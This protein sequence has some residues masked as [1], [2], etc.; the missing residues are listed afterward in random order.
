MIRKLRFKFI[1]LTMVSLFLVLAVIMGAVNIFNYRKIVT[2]AD[3]TLS[4][5]RDNNGTFP[6]PNRQESH[7]QDRPG[8]PGDGPLSPELPY[9]SRY[10]SVLLSQSGEVLQTDTGKIA[11]VDDGTAAQF[12]RYLYGS[13][14]EKGFLGSYRY[15]V[16]ERDSGIQIIFLDC[17]RSLSTFRTFLFTSCAISVLGLLTVFVLILMFSRRI[18][19]PVSESYEKQ[20]RFTTDAGHELKTPITIIS[21][22]AE[23]LEMEFG[24]NEWIK[25]IQRQT[26]RLASLTNDLIFLSRMEEERTRL[27]EIVF[28]LSDLVS[29]TA[30]S[31]QTLAKS[32]HKT[33]TAN[34]QPMLSF[35][36]NEK[37][38]R[39][40]VCVLLDNALK[41]SGRGGCILLSLSEQKKN[42]CL[43]VENTT[44]VVIPEPPDRLFDR[45]YRADASR[46]S[47][48]EGHGLG[49]SIA[50]AVTDAHKGKISVLSPESG[51][52][53]VQVLLPAHFR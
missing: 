39:Q 5:L 19:R 44:D 32:Q 23:V 12:A 7:I 50:K 11:A 18:I 49:L 6:F 15:T 53:R 42:I 3:N 37:A 17:Q 14:S 30:Q 2:E 52:L 22:D 26:E 16:Q 43:F 34:I 31:F 10:F 41:Y 9:E 45:F 40:L 47:Q 36:G 38:L 48:T 35:R 25:D 1:I 13:G 4:I 21:A 33:F 29:E 28:P 8:N 24:E 20:K 46:S 27:E 51:I